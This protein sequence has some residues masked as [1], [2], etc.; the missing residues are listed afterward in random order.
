MDFDLKLVDLKLTWTWSHVV[1]VDLALKL[2]DLKLTWTRSHVVL[3]DLALKLV[4][5]KLTWTCLLLDLVQVIV[6][7]A[8]MWTLLIAAHVHFFPGRLAATFQR[9]RDV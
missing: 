9:T 2:V 8:T 6:F 4:D 5:L 1:L 3:V 7:T